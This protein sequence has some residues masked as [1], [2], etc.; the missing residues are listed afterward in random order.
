MALAYR[1]DG[2]AKRIRTA[3]TMKQRLKTWVKQENP[4]VLHFLHL[5]QA[6]LHYCSH[7]YDAAE[8]EYEAAIKASMRTG[9]KL[10]YALSN[11]LLSLFFADRNNS[12]FDM[13]KARF[14]M[15]SSVKS[16]ESYGAA[17]K[18]LHMKDAYSNLLSSS[19][20]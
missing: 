18:V 12:L 16:Y 14:Y 11:E 9:F 13:K 1:V 7:K 10:D 8:E 17:N 15:E 4:N 3:K 20:S 6:E 19:D 5:L 2:K